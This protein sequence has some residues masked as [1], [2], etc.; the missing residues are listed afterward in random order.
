MKF[1]LIHIGSIK[2]YPPALSV[3]Q[4]LRDLNHE[5]SLI[6]TNID[7]NIKE[8]CL[9]RNITIYNMDID[10]EKTI[11]TYLK[12]NRL[13]R[14]KKK[15]WKIIDS[16]YDENTVL[17][18]FSDLALKHLGKELLNYR[19]VLHMFELSEYTLYYRR[20][21]RLKIDTKI[22]A[23]SSLAVI[24][25]EYN[26]AHIAKT[27]WELEWTPFILPNKPYE[28]EV[29]R[30]SKI[31][32]NI[33][34]EI[35]SKLSNKK[36]ILYQGIITDERPIEPFMKAVKELGTDY[37]LVIMTSSEIKK[38]ISDYNNTYFVPFVSPPF[39]LQVTSHAY[40]GVL[41]YV[42]TSNSEFSKLNSIYCAPNKIFEYS[43]FG[44]PMIGNDIPGLSL[45]FRQYTS[46][47][48]FTDFTEKDI[49]SS[50]NEIEKEYK[51]YSMGSSMLY[52][53]VNIKNIIS[54]IINFIR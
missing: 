24:Q 27:W 18:V 1:L 33:A 23:Q 29:K 7:E 46:G 35:I 51:A 5:V 37:A 28:I 41:S 40:I 30:F 21:S 16:V 8:L 9:K 25:A 48:V 2:R 4:H 38:N 34:S 12:F 26:R 53:S 32:D 6:T 45:P 42:P 11:P 3:L 54:D 19:Y 31:N 17:W 36:I 22:F 10:Y 14:I 20:L 13:L 15:L 44:I 47:T 50:I 39:H 52:N 49:I 43:K